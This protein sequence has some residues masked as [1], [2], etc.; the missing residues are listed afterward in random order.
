TARRVLQ[1]FPSKEPARRSSTARRHDTSSSARSLTHPP[2][3]RARRLP[4]KAA[5]PRPT[6]L[7]VDQAPPLFTPVAARARARGPPYRLTQAFC[8]LFPASI[9]A[10]AHR[11]TM[12]RAACHL[13]APAEVPEPQMFIIPPRSKFIFSRPG[14]KKRNAVSVT[15]CPGI[16]LLTLHSLLHTV[17]SVFQMERA[18]GKSKLHTETFLQNR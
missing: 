10:L 12:L 3:L 1:L 9:L 5:R 15:D 17:C 13:E 7:A 14:G 6:P 4:A 2:P 18:S 16:A 11:T 8:F